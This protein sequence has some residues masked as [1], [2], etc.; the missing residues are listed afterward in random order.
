MAR[1][2]IVCTTQVPVSEPNR[3]AHIV[4]VGT[5]NNPPRV[6]RRWPLDE[7][8]RAMDSGDSFFT[9]GVQSGKIAE[10]EKYQCPNCRRT[11]IRS[12]PDAVADNNLDN[13][14]RC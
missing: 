4:E 11:Y 7:V 14:P 13:L 8:L 5:G 6:D 2:R 9:Q 1:Y 12:K 10:V 3:N